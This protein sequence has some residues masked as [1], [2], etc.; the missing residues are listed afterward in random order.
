MRKRFWKKGIAIGLS[1]FALAF[2]FTGMR[3]RKSAGTCGNVGSF[4]DGNA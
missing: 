2:G 1:A 3:R 4:M